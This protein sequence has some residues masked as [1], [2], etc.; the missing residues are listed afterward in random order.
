MTKSTPTETLPMGRVLIVAGSD[1]SGGAGIQ[2]DI[3]TVTMLGGYAAAALTAL[4]VQ[5]TTAVTDVLAIE[6]RFVADQMQVVLS[7]VGADSIKTG[8]LHN[9]DVMSA[10]ADVI[11]T[12]KFDG[13]VVVDPVMVASSGAKLIDDNALET[14]RTILLPRAT[15][16]TPNMPEAA[17][18]VGRPVETFEDMTAAARSLIDMGAGA[19]VVKGGH[20]GG[21]MLSDFVLTDSGESMTVS[22]KKIDTR[23]THGTG[24]SLASG[25]ATGLAQGKRLDK[26]FEAA[27][28][29]V[30]QAI[31]LAPGLG[32]GHGPLGHARVPR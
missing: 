8:M 9:A 12:M 4:T 23:S 3:K 14:M 1:P 28:E 6:P 32:A 27:H 18:L 10:V 30:Q 19:A 7:D 17:L 22:R 26:A 20:M 25:I 11:D 21:D 13:D 24:C 29:F 31:R 16:V 15:V 2:A 5:N